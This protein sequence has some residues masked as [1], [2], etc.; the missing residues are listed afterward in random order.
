MKLYFIYGNKQKKSLVESDYADDIY[1]VIISFFE[2][3]NSFPHVITLGRNEGD[4]VVSIPNT[5]E[6][7][8]ILD[9]SDEQFDELDEL[10]K[11]YKR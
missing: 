8:L 5:L 11:D 1:D 9:V 2:D 3:H 6:H 10:V 7:F 4:A